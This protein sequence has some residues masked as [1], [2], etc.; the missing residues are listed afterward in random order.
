MLDDR[1]NKPS[2]FRIINWIEINNESK[3]RYDNSNIRFKRYIIKSSLCHYNNPYLLIKGTITVP[4]TEAAGVAV[5]IA[6]K[7]MIFESY[8]DCI[9]EIN[10]TQIDDAQTND[11]VILKY[12]LTE[13]SNAY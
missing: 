6:N 5:N 13:H 7:N 12:K 8:T 10:N 4:K 11:V 2:K 1:T 9:T 3:K